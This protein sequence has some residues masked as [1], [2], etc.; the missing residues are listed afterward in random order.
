MNELNK[1][2]RMECPIHGIRKPTFIC[3]H[4]QYGNGLGF[5]VSAE[6]DLDLPFQH[7]WCQKCDDVLEQ[8][9]TWNDLSEK[10]ASPIV[11]CEGCFETIRERNQVKD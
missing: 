7:A 8:T 2:S 5:I 1:D 11:I 9:G 4:L 10:F 3:Q 6:L